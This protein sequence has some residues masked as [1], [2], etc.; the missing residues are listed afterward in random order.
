MRT[1][2][3][4]GKVAL[5]I[6][7]ALCA[8]ATPAVRAQT[9]SNTATINWTIGTTTMSRTSNRVDIAM[10]TPV[11]ATL[12]LS[13][14][15]FSGDGN[16]ERLVVPETI[17][18]G[19]AG[20]APVAL[21]GAFAGTPLNL[22][23]V[24][25]TSAIRAGAPLVVSIGSPSDNR[26]STAVE[27]L[28][29]TLTT[30][31]GDGETLVLRETG[32][33]TGLFAGVV[34]TTAVPPIAVMGDCQLSIHPG[35][36]L[37]L[38]FLRGDT[39]TTL[40]AVPISVLIDPF[41][42]VFD[43]G[44]GSP[45]AGTRVT[46]IDVETG[47]PAIVFGDDGVSAFPSSV[48]TGTTVTDASG[49]SYAFPPGD[50]RFP[51]VRPGRYRLLVEPPAPY[52][53]PSLSTA[54]ELA[55]LRRP[56]G[57]PFTIGA[58][59]YGAIFVLSDPAPV[60]TDIPV[61]RPGA[62]LDLRKTASQ[63]VAVPGDGIQYRIVVTNGDATRSTGA[64]TVSDRLPAAM[65]LKADTVRYNGA[66]T[67][68][69][70]TDDGSLLSVTLPSLAERANGVLTYLLE[71]RP[72][73]QPGDT[74]NRAQAR[75]TRGSI[76]PVADAMVRIARDGIGDRLTI[77]GRVTDGGCVVD[78][79][80]ASGIG[81]VRVMLEDGSYAVTDIDGRYHF[82]GVLPGTHVVQIDPS[83]L[84]ASLVPT[85]CARN[86]R[87]AGSAISRFVEG[88]GGVLLR[89]DFRARSGTNAAL[90][91]LVAAK[92]AAP[93][94][95]PQ[96]AGAERDWFSGQTPGIAWL[97]P[98]ADHNPRTKAVRVSIKHLPGQIV[99]LFANGKPVE[100]L[101]FDGTRQNADASIAVSLWRALELADG[102]TRFTAEVR[103][104]SGALVEQLVRDVHFSANPIRAELLRD[105]STLVADGVTRPVIALRLSDRDGRPVHHGLV[106][107]FAVPAPYEP[108]VAVD[109]QA[110]RQ[111]SGLERARPVWHV[112]SD[113][114]IAYVEL[115]PTTASGALHVTLPFRDGEV[116]RAQ[117]IDLWL[118]P[119]NRPWTVVSFAAGTVGFNTLK[120]RLEGLGKDGDHWLSDARLALYAKGRVRGKWLLTLAYDTD[121]NDD[122]TRFAGVIDP[123]A[124]YTIY[125]D[126]SERRY[127]A[128]SIRRLYVKLE[129]PQFYALFGDYAT[130]MSDAQLTRYNRAFNGLKAQ[131]RSEQ[132]GA[133]A[134]AA[135][136]PFRHR[137]EELQGTGLSGPYGIAAR[138]ILPNS[139]RIVIET[140]DR[141]RADRIV[142]SRTLVRHIDYDIDYLA[143]TLRFRE[144]VLS[145]SSGL[146]PQFIV[147][148]Y[149][150]NGVAARVVN[151]GG[152]ATWNNTARTLSVGA[153]AIHDEDDRAR[154]DVGGV[155]IRYTPNAATE[156]RA[157]VAISH[158]SAKAGTTLPTTGTA[159][160]WLV[161]AE[162]HGPRYDVL[163][164]AK[165][166]EAGFGVG[167]TNSGEN[168]TRKFGADGRV[169]IAPELSLVGSAWQENYLG[170]GAQRQAGRASVE[171]RTKAL[172]LRAGVQIAA[173]RLADGRDADSTVAQLGA[174][175]RLFGNRLE[176]DTQTEFAL[177]QSESIDFPARHRVGARF[178]ATRD[179][180]LVAGY[181]VA[182]GDTVDANTARIGF[183]IKPWAGA[184]LIAAANRQN[185][186]EYGPRSYADYGLAQSLPIGKR[187]TV[188]FSLDGSQTL[189]GID[190]RRV[191]NL[192]HPVA[193][194]GFVGT[195]GAVSEDFV[196]VTGG[197]SFRG[198]RW[199]WT[200]RAEH[201]A[202]D[203][204]DRYG[205]TTSALRQ[206]GEGE[207]LGGIFSWFRAKDKAG[208]RT[209]ATS[210][211][212][213]WAR[214]PDDSR[215]AWLEKLELR[216]D[217]VRGAIAGVPG[218]I[219]G[220]PL[221][222][223]GDAS[224]K[225]VINSLSVNWSPTR[226]GEGRYLGRSEVALFWGSRYVS[227]KVGADDISGWSNLVGLDL[228]FDLS[229]TL[230]L[231][232]AG[233][234]RESAS[235]KAIS[236]SGGPAI[237]IS[238]FKG[239][240]IS[241]GYNVAG[242]HDRD[243]SDARYTRSGPYV[244][245]RFKF[246][247]T[248]LLR[249]GSR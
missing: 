207:T 170:S 175:K 179:V 231:G 111:L 27:T 227:D 51:F 60:R 239:S 242:F 103:D 165:Q 5:S 19:S 53:A 94:S 233:T 46:L 140:R 52:T 69:T 23:S 49:T 208:P 21:E 174:T 47:A 189:G 33:N 17:C 144:P 172:D 232:V 209:E 42:I 129:R 155:D 54:T 181:E 162:H 90:G 116:S 37:T 16:A 136:T 2:N 229:E 220:A 72:D 222:I 132:V 203:R 61:D 20:D 73:A 84:G 216:S 194:G 178:A 38:T 115:E 145:R 226:K 223:S 245:L 221:T 164:Y 104:A 120:G 214:R 86:A 191:L 130:D 13:T 142:D 82:E 184:R 14:F 43:S 88:Q 93:L 62:P 228:R 234:V 134:F 148:D 81:G 107:E 22:A 97:F 108:A 35:E 96:A 217:V 66:Q 44:D 238:P 67:P 7:A 95:E 71:V 235:G 12:T 161:E 4:L 113:D 158:A 199:S 10:S 45:V 201:R 125:A 77:I 206:L 30:P 188:D 143:G 193:S 28:T 159:T 137:R 171:Y 112:E 50:Y 126:R 41:G 122:E 241:V 89:V 224:S 146:D 117:R 85:D 32:A 40:A 160:A 180:T 110:A 9:I 218:P 76:S 83:S 11:P 236:Y 31:G 190:P 211:A 150:V 185:I 200:G 157:E 212:L 205:V 237:G 65:R 196:A 121:K 74:M 79:D 202:G 64:I 248:T 247:Q 105:R 167:Q 119:G 166:Q 131:Y 138:D 182:R 225:R 168:G 128:A 3:L 48:V 24:E 195:G 151:A 25:R 114:G 219:G 15:Q 215:F 147:I 124:Y 177:G 246:D 8:M 186:G 78:P 70:I 101:S 187:W 230:D 240:Y 149:E 59:S 197:A 68:Y 156:I 102:K 80:S 39:G 153:S 6:A 58:G 198:D 244:T 63:P 183:D 36:S 1:I 213:S 99:T 118:D 92:R 141:L 100:P 18:R 55:S 98:D 29:V 163:A 176:L 135:D 249:N 210:L 57:L 139:E 56:D 173:D 26:N 243:Y 127:D 123:Q 75:D 106:G 154:T 169:R 87:S 152:R 133:T 204:T 91:S 34:R 109:A 192:A